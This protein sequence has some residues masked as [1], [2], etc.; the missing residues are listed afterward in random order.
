MHLGNFKYFI[1]WSR[2]QFWKGT[3]AFCPWGRVKQLRLVKKRKPWDLGDDLV[4]SQ[5]SPIRG[6]R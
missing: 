4:Q 2:G 1:G 5:T 6:H 3:R